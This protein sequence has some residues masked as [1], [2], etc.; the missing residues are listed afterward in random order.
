VIFFVYDTVVDNNDADLDGSVK[1]QKKKKWIS[2]E[3]Y[4]AIR[5]RGGGQK[6]KIRTDVKS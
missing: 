4:E 3:T 2:D 5:E 6:A 1:S